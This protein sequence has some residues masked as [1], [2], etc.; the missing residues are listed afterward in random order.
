MSKDIRDGE[1]DCQYR[2]RVTPKKNLPDVQ[3]FQISMASSCYDKLAHT[4]LLQM[5]SRD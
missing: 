4:P 3:A 2:S 5:L 1:R